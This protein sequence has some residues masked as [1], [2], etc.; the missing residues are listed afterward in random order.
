MRMMI[1]PNLV[2]FNFTGDII[3]GPGPLEG[4]QE[5]HRI[6]RCETRLHEVVS[7]KGLIEALGAFNAGFGVSIGVV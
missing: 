4:R 7:E 1:E 6:Q 3:C 2:P 5:H